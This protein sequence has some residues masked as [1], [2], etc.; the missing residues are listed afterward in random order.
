MKEIRTLFNSVFGKKS[1]PVSKTQFQFA[2]INSPTFSMFG[3]NIYASDV[4]RAC[5]HVIASNVAKAKPKYIVKNSTGVIPQNG[6]FQ[7][8]IAEQPN[9]I[10]NTYDFIYK[11]VTQ[12]ELN[13]NAF[14]YA[15]ID[16]T[17]VNG[18]YTIDSNTANLVCDPM[19][20]LYLRF[21]TWMGKQY[22]FP[23]ESIIHLRK[24]YANN[25]FY[26]DNPSNALMPTLQLLQ[27]TNEGISNGVKQS[28]YIRGLLTVQGML[29]PDDIEKQKQ[30]FMNDFLSSSNNGGVIVS[31]SK[32]S[33]TPLEM[34]P[35]LV[36][37]DQMAEI[38]NMVYR[39]FNL[40]EGIVT[41]KYTEQDW[42][43]FYEN[44]IEPVCLQ[45]SLEFTNKLFT[46]T[47]RSFGNQIIFE[48]NRLQYASTKTKISLA[49]DLAAYGLFTI[50]E[51]REVFNLAPVP[52][53]DK[54]LQTL[55]VV[56]AQR[57]DEYQLGDIQDSKNKDDSNMGDGDIKD[58]G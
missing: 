21:Y 35:M 37:A 54:R 10:Q 23:Y 38:R 34:K 55:N 40:N 51:M 9:K 31:D 45:L 25:E 8:M 39:F 26:G 56:N 46:P 11:L 41:S 4:V 22:T 58:E 57:A 48:T 43:S 7:R 49:K 19:G 13:G 3:N 12:L 20:N 50:N 14:A 18:L 28:A 47:E 27:T 52:D 33:F 17:Q 32:G 24:H 30:Q 15:D 42:D 6:T 36:D 5:I 16:G 1:S 53:G 29:Q 2:D 44:C